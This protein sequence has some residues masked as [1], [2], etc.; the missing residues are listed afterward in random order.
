M[1]VHSTQAEVGQGILSPQ[2]HFL[3]ISLLSVKRSRM[4]HGLLDPPFQNDTYHLLS[5]LDDTAISTLLDIYIDGPSQIRSSITVT[6][7]QTR[8]LSWVALLYWVPPI[9]VPSAASHASLMH[10]Q[11][12]P[13]L[14]CPFHHTMVASSW[15]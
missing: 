7:L 6:P 10:G 11:F 1:M 3:T 4:I 8:P 13:W 12:Q 9:R 5:L 15:A 2:T 14:D